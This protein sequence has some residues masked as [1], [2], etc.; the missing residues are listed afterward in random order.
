M[1]QRITK[2][3]A[4]CCVIGLTLLSAGAYAQALTGR[5]VKQAAF[6]DPS[7]EL[8]GATANGKLYVLG[9][10]EP[11]AVPKGAVYE[12]DPAKDTWIK[13]KNMM[14]PAH[15]M[16]IVEHGGKLYVFGGFVL[17]PQSKGIWAPI[18]KIGRA[19]V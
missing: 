6:P 5:W 12:Y 7:E 17:P 8:V 4:G 3:L 1:K 9:G 15:H 10:Y 11:G 14:Q 18:D 2:L 16:A 13:K 19:H